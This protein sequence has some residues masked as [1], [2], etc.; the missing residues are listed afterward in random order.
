[1]SKKTKLH[2]ILAVES[3]LK[4]KSAK[5]VED[6]ANSFSKRDEHYVGMK[7]VYSSFEE[8]GEMVPNEGKEVV[9][10]VKDKLSYALNSVIEAIDATVTK[11]EANCS[12]TAK[13]MLSVDGVD[14]GEL[15]ATSLLALESQLVALRDN[16][17]KQ[18]PTLENTRTWKKVDGT[19]M[20]A[21]EPQLKYRTVNRQKH[22]VVVPPTENHPAQVAVTTEVVQ[23]GKYEQTDYAGKIRS[24]DKANILERMDKLI[25][26]V[27]A[28]RSRANNVDIE[29]VKI[30]KRLFEYINGVNL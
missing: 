2:E 3:D 28:A 4:K 7:K 14:M 9:A 20:Y 27:K 21:S 18:I 25:N 10:T 12:G 23:V 17:Y 6:T 11:E 29:Q 30:G 13:T 24:I 1:M 5:L 16:V 19:N 8:G 26:A 22:V 15:S